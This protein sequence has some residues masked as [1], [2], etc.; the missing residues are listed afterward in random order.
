MK[1]NIT[2]IGM[3]GAGKTTIGKLL[4]K[5]LNMGFFDMDAEIEREQDIPIVQIFEKFG[6]EHFRVL[7]NNLCKKILQ[8]NG[9]VISTG[10]GVV[11]NPEN[12]SIIRQTSIAIYLHATPQSI[13]SRLLR[14][15]SRPLLAGG[16]LLHIEEILKNRQ[17]LYKGAADITI[18]TENKTPRKIVL[19]ILPLL[20]LREIT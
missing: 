20:P 11:L 8:M 3:M 6:E 7:E 10:G 12:I 2:L 17:H 9:V 15:N 4:S 5:T 16:Q 1:P 18:T 14:D 19:E 13:Y